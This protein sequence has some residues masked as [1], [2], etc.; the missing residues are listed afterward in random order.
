VGVGLDRWGET[1]LWGWLGQVRLAINAL[2]VK[3]GLVR[4]V[5]FPL[6]IPVSMLPPIFSNPLTLIY[7]PQR[8]DPPWSP[9]TPSTLI[10]PHQP[11][12]PPQSPATPLEF[13]WPPLT[14]VNPLQPLGFIS[15]LVWTCLIPIYP[16]LAFTSFKPL[17]S[18]LVIHLSS[19][20]NMIDTYRPFDPF[21]EKADCA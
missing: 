7:C 14:P 9:L 8:F 1:A 11:C 12:W 16:P 5:C 6:L 20:F 2:L 19:H 10:D 18:K 17:N 3:G 13:H 15:T 4:T 21:C